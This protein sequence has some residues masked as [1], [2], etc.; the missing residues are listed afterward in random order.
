MLNEYGG[1]WDLQDL[2]EA[3]DSDTVFTSE[4]GDKVVKE[5]CGPRDFGEEEE[6]ALEDDEEMV[7]DRE[8]VT[9][10]LKRNTVVIRP[11]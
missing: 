4:N 2:H 1:T 6:D 8:H 9:T 3:E 5:P 11:S 7:D 10:G